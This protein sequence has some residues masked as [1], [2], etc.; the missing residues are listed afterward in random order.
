MV[1][2]I[3]RNNSSGYFSNKLFHINIY[4]CLNAITVYNE[5]IQSFSS[6]IA[7]MYNMVE[8]YIDILYIYSQISY[9]YV[10][11]ICTTRACVSM[12]TRIII[13]Y[14]QTLINM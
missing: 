1:I 12:C 4:V 2:I 3:I 14:L 10:L 7:Y 11:Y 6:F 9:I 5:Y 8:T 13:Y